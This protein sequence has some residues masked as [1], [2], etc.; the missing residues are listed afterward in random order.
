MGNNEMI[1]LHSPSPEEINFTPFLKLLRLGHAIKATRLSQLVQAAVRRL[2]TKPEHKIQDMEYLRRQR[3]AFD[4]PKRDAVYKNFQANLNDIC[5]AIQ[6]SGAT[7]I[8]ATLAVNL[9]DFPPLA[10]LHR[11]GLPPA[12]LVEWEKAFEE[13]VAAEARKEIAE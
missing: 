2:G 9:H 11:H 6:R 8:L 10:S 13:G 1:G 3:L 7:T 12:Q 4:D 5:D